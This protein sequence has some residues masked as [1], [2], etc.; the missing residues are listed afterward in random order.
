MAN[1]PNETKWW[2][3]AN[4]PLNDE[5]WRPLLFGDNDELPAARELAI[6]LHRINAPV[7]FRVVPRNDN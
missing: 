6:E 5:D 2:L 1:C 3:E 4:N 7:Q